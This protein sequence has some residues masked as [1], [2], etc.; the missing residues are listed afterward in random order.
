MLEQANHHIGSIYCVDWT[1]TEHLL[2]TGS[3]DRFIKLL[4]CPDL[5]QHDEEQA[6]ILEMTLQGHQAIVRSVC[7]NPTND[8]CLLSGG[9]VDT[10]LKVW[11]TETGK[12]IANLKGHASDIHSIKMASDGSFAISVS[13]DKKILLFDVRAKAAVSIMD[14]SQH[15]I[16]HDVALSNNG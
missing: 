2:A 4:V 15:S 14:A 12:N 8:L 1:K 6:E 7:F 11:N 13:K 10:E 16:M 9:Q 3:N 5:T